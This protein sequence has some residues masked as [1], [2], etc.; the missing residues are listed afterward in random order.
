MSLVVSNEDLVTDKYPRFVSTGLEGKLILVRG[1]RG[2]PQ[3]RK[4]A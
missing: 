2:V 4:Y 1:T 3:V